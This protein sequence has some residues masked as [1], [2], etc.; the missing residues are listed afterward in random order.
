MIQILYVCHDNR[1]SPELASRLHSLEES[2]WKVR[3]HI[4]HSGKAV[5]PSS[6]IPAPDA[7]VADL[8]HTENTGMLCSLREAADNQWGATPRIPLLALVQARHLGALEWIRCSGDF[9][10][11][12]HSPQELCHRILAL[13]RHRNIPPTQSGVLALP[14]TRIH[15]RD[16]RAESETGNDLPLT[17]REFELLTFLAKNRGRYFQRQCLLDRVW[18]AD[19]DGSERTVDVHV[20]RL[21]A[22]LPGDTASLLET[23]HG[24]GY[25]LRDS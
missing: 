9:Q 23:R 2:G 10:C 13:L 20:R 5:I 3:V 15:T 25:G 1:R 21:R 4:T 24:F 16:G 19:F 6:N 14:G 17:H 7:L 11:P 22:K 12:P 18:G 8:A